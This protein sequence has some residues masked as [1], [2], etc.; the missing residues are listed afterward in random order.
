MIRIIH[1]SDIHLEK[2]P[3][4][5]NTTD[6]MDA[7]VTNL[8][9]VVD[10]NT[11]LVITGDLIDKGGVGFKSDSTKPYDH[12]YDTVLYRIL[13]N[14]PILEDK[15]LFVPGNHD[16]ERR[17]IDEFKKNGILS[18]LNKSYGD[19][20]NSIKNN[21]NQKDYLEQLTQFKLFEG[22]LF[23]KV[24]NYNFSYLHSTFS[25]NIAG[26]KVGFACLNSAW[27]CSGDDD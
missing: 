7:L 23:D 20:N 25:C 21:I 9:S 6:L 24:D 3:I 12:F 2:P 16:I 27:L 5:P 8:N 13:E 17:K 15:I 22:Q 19:F 4:S 10:E 14:Y 26:Q 11:V 18:T 1:I